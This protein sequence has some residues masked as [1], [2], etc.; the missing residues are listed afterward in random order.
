MAATH[1][2]VVTYTIPASAA[3]EPHRYVTAA[4]AYASAGG[5]GL[6]LSARAAANTELLPVDLVGIS[7]ATAGA[8]VAKGAALEVGSNGKLVT[9]ASGVTVAQA[10]ESATADQL[11]SVN[12][13]PN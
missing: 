8:D 6:G 7:I 12:L 5:R 10:L 2:S 1:Y 3:I 4:G 13:I 11:F 9:S